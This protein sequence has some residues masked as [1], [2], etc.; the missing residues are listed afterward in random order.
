MMLGCWESRLQAVRRGKYEGGANR[1]RL[2][3]VERFS[4]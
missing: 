1:S 2:G 3:V 4:D